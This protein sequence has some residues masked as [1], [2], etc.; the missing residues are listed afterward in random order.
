M[1]NVI[2]Y[3]MTLFGYIIYNMVYIL[4]YTFTYNHYVYYDIYTITHIIS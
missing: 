4:H 1:Y 2:Y 3:R